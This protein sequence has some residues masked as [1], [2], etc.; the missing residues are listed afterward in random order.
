MDNFTTDTHRVTERC[1]PCNQACHQGRAC[2]SRQACGLPDSDVDD[3][4]F[5]AKACVVGISILA[6]L[7]AASP[8]VLEMVK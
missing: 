1:P 4:G 8:V 2:P 5:I 7:C 6:L 3:I